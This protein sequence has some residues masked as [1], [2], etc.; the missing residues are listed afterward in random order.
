M[1]VYGQGFALVCDAHWLLGADAVHS[2]PY[3]IWLN[4]AISHVLPC[5]LSAQQITFWANVR[6]RKRETRV[7]PSPPSAPNQET[8]VIPATDATNERG[9]I[10][11]SA[12]LV[13][14]GSLMSS[15]SF[16]FHRG[17]GQMSWLENKR[18]K[19]ENPARQPTSAVSL[20]VSSVFRTAL[21]AAYF[22]LIS[23]RTSSLDVNQPADFWVCTCD[24]R[25]TLL[26]PAPTIPGVTLIGQFRL[27]T[28]KIIIKKKCLNTNNSESR[29]LA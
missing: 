7:R 22:F 27:V 26:T 13:R 12:E 29:L 6:F 19:L 3:I 16:I 4:D 15:D 18:K 23:S 8:D 1:C 9:F 5:K 17:E 21:G 24:W 10:L 25:K 28:S 2:S 14:G 20:S 11:L